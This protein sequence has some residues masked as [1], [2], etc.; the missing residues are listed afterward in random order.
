[1]CASFD[2]TLLTCVFQPRYMSFDLCVRL[3]P[4]SKRF[5]QMARV[6]YRQLDHLDVEHFLARLPDVNW[7]R[8][9]HSNCPN[10]KSIDKMPIKKDNLQ[11]DFIST[12]F[13]R[14]M[15]SVTRIGLEW[16]GVSP[17]VMLFLS[18]MPNLIRVEILS[19]DISD[20]GDLNLVEKLRV[21]SLKCDSLSWLQFFDPDHLQVLEFTN[22]AYP[23]AGPNELM[24]VLRKYENLREIKVGYC[25]EEYPEEYLVEFM[26]FASDFLK[27]QL[28]VRLRYDFGILEHDAHPS[29][30]K[31]VT[32]LELYEMKYINMETHMPVITQLSN[33]NQLS[34]NQ[35]QRPLDASRWL[36]SLPS[37]STLKANSRRYVEWRKFTLAVN[38]TT[39]YKKR[40]VFTFVCQIKT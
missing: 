6:F 1:M 39:S 8:K 38:F 29:I 24:Q 7:A 32:D 40:C 5:Q 11:R 10:L 3:E 22:T 12:E 13:V 4:V 33:L 14:K 26:D 18:D 31:H 23:K 25:F 15:T 17:F 21:T 19:T 16:G 35:L 2:D 36:S 27:A 20:P 30:R 28:S 37:L 9:I 34:F